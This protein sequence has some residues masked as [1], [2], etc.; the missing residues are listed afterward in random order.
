MPRP[1]ALRAHDTMPA[2]VVNHA[3][4][5]SEGFVITEAQRA[6]LDMVPDVAWIKDRKGRFIATNAAFRR[7]YNLNNGEHHSG[8][9]TGNDS[10]NLNPAAGM[11]DL[12][13]SPPAQAA[14]RRAEDHE[15]ISSLATRTYE[16]Q[17][18]CLGVIRWVEVTKSPVLDV[19][20]C[21][22]GTIGIL[23]DTTERRAA[24]RRTRDSEHRFRMLTQLSSDWYWEQDAELRFTVARC[25]ADSETDYSLLL[26]KRRWDLAVEGVTAEQWAAHRATL[27][28]HKPFHG[29]EYTVQFP[30]GKRSFSASGRP[31]FDDYGVFL[32]YRGVGRD[33][34]QQARAA[35]DLAKATE[36]L[37]IALEAAS[38]STWD[39][40]VPSGTVHLSEGWAKLIGGEA[41]RR[42]NRTMSPGEL[43]ASIHPDDTAEV[44]RAFVEVVKAKRPEYLAEHRVRSANG[45]WKWVLSRGKVMQRDAAGH[46]LRV[47]GTNLDITER[48]SMESSVRYALEQSQTVFESAPSALAV[49]AD[50]MIQRCNSAMEQMF[51]A[52]PGGLTGK[53]LRSLYGSE[54]EWSAVSSQ[55]L[56]AWSRDEIYKAEFEFIRSSGEHFWAMVAA[57]R[58]SRE[59]TEALFSFA[60]VSQQQQ[61]AAALE[62]ARNDSDAAN[63]AKSGFLAMMSHEIRTPMNG[64]LGMLEL[65][66]LSELDTDQREALGLIRESSVSL[67]RLVD[68]LLDFSKIEAGQLEIRPEPMS[69]PT[70]ASRSTTIYLELASRKRIVLECHV[71]PQLSP[72]HVADSLRVSQILN[73]L[74]SNAIKFTARGKVSLHIESAGRKLNM[75]Q[76]KISVTDTGIGVTPEQQARLFQPF[77]QG[78][79]ETTRKYGGSGLGLA[80]CRR[81][82]EMM[83]GHIIMRSTH[84]EGTTVEV[85][86]R[87]PVTEVSVIPARQTP[88]LERLSHIDSSANPPAPSAHA[89]RV[90]I[91]EDHPVNLKLLKRQINLLGYLSDVASDGVEGLEK[92]RRES[93]ALVLTD[94]QMPRMD[95]YQL[96]RE[97]RKLE[98]SLGGKNAVPI[99]ACT[100]NA[101]ASDAEL[102]L[103]AGMN[104]YLPK[105]ITL[106][107][108][109]SKLDRWIGEAPAGQILPTNAAEGPGSEKPV[110]AYAVLD[111]TA[112][113]QFTGGSE[114]ERI[115]ILSDFLEANRNDTES[116]RSALA[117][118][119][120]ASIVR[121][122]HRVKGASRMIG[123]TLFSETA[124]SIERAARKGT[125]SAIQK[126][127][128]AFE[129][130]H[131]RLV[132][133]LMAQTGANS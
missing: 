28:S 67:L 93:Y 99:I 114:T 116:L 56:G 91:V 108:L 112:L 104:D 85:L 95:G 25:Y 26:G 129:R 58:I 46:A 82:A 118:N 11:T 133:Y 8:H 16:Y 23:R 44:R 96:A 55:A 12:D 81:L 105:P 29:F 130:E 43:M 35:L 59:S 119:D 10:G 47:S 111:P 122:S 106:P 20:N 102:C 17:E 89:P 87:L 117:Q 48:K 32:G 19:Q 94:C 84:G 90:L 31:V 110:S 41:Q 18:D 65:L 69:L 98:T 78:D 62:K 132:S 101:L 64:V 100:A 54:A 97:I 113:T 125:L 7:R 13:F 109:K 50:G 5:L 75:E 103:V 61:L 71:D 66:D 123:A 79:A 77:V 76:V 14:Q 45:Q 42:I 121:W 39:L 15:V 2:P 124:E 74:L 37:Q 1:R 36:R 131:A 27:Q 52:A 21:V 4:L 30:N 51:G 3:I 24:E 73:N 70:L 86:L 107:G 68:D 83:G 9:Y 33:I 6:L 88:R 80:I 127:V 128:P 63:K 40:D 38:L 57:K 126:C 49:V 34:T 60:D 53:P 92:W 120:V 72:A 115:E 22:A